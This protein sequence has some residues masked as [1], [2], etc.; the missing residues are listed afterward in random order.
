MICLTRIL[1][2]LRSQRM[3]PGALRRTP[4][5]ASHPSRK[6]SW[7]KFAKQLAAVIRWVLPADRVAGLKKW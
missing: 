3:L 6:R 2:T 1:H 7:T 5:F 4:C